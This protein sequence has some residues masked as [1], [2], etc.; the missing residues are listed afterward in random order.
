MSKDDGT[1]DRREFLRTIG[2]IAAL[3]GLSLLG[4]KLAGPRHRPAAG[5]TCVSDGVCPKCSALGECGTP[6]A[7]SFKRGTGRS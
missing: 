5:E 6:Q 2:R 4:I 1:M 3:G 7:L